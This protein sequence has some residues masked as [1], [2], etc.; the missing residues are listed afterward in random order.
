MK[1]GISYHGERNNLIY[2]AE[3]VDALSPASDK[4]STFLRYSDTETSAAVCY[5]AKGYKVISVGF[6]I[7]LI[8]NEGALNAFMSETMNFLK[9]D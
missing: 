6:P 3:N 7:E 5:K 1:N 2:N 9:K 4:S 8:T